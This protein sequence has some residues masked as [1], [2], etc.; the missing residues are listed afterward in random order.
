MDVRAEEGPLQKMTGFKDTNQ[1]GLLYSYKNCTCDFIS[2]GPLYLT[3]PRIPVQRFS[4]YEEVHIWI[5]SDVVRLN[6]TGLIFS[7]ISDKV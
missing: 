1:V 5:F 4:H 7:G 2:T 6:F 3:L